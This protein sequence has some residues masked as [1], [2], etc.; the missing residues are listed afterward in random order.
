MREKSRW[1]KCVL[2]LLVCV[3]ALCVCFSPAL[4]Q[5]GTT[6]ALVGVVTDP[7]GAVIV[8]AIVTA[9]NTGTGA[10]RTVTTTA[11]GAY[12]FSL[13]PP[14]DYNVKFEAPGFQTSTV[15]AVTVNV[16]ESPVLNH[17]MTVGSQ[18]QQVTV[19]A[20]AENIQT[21]N[22]TVGGLV[23]GRE[24]T[25]LPLSTRNYTQIMDL[26]PGVATNVASA[27]NFGIGTQDVNVNGSSSEHNN[28]QMEGTSIVNY[29]SGKAGQENLYGP[30]PVPNPDAVQEFKV[31][32]SQFDASYGRNS[33]GNVNVVLKT[34]TNNYHGDVW[35]FNRNNFF[36]ANDFF[37]KITEK[38]TGAPNS[39][40]TLK[41]NTCLAPRLAVRIMKDKLFFFGS[42]Q[43]NRQVNGITSVGY[44]PGGESAGHQ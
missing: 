43:D 6:G 42:Y 39:P 1:E 12:Q 8:G 37:E 36:N 23:S 4:A 30:I 9:T 38:S 7:S 29:M 19:E 28:Y 15:P 20:T 17:S 26:S 18:T 27:T 3:V 2:S 21:E 14:G 32:T 13:L 40:Q 5:T 41:Q 35:E 10:T 33:G 25:A 11:T 44:Q 34:G 24:V 22:A 16:T 31:Q